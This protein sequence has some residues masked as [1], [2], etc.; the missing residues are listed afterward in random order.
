MSLGPW[1][2][3]ALVLGGTVAGCY[4]LHEFVIRRVA[5]IRPLFGLKPVKRSAHAVVGADLSAIPAER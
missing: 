1:L 2:E 3:P 4:V 5:F